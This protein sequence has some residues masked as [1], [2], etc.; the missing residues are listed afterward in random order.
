MTFCGG[1]ENV[2]NVNLKNKLQKITTQSVY[3]I[4]NCSKSSYMKFDVDVSQLVDVK[5]ER[6]VE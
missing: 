5:I 3:N 2:H 6:R 1:I 4:K